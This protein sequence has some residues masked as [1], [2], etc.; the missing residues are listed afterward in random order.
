MARFSDP[1]VELITI[2]CGSQMGKTESLMNVLGHRFADGPRVPTLWIAPTQ[3]SVKSLA[4]DRVM[5]MIKGTPALWDILDK[6]RR[7]RMVEKFLA[8]VRLGFGWA[9]SA[10]ELASHPAGLVLVD[11]RD[12]MVSDV[13][14]EGDPLVLARARTKNYPLRKIGVSSTPTIEGASPIWSLFLEGTREKW[15]W[16]CPHCAEYFVPRLEYLVWPKKATPGEARRAAFVVCPSCG[17]ELRDVDK[18]D[19]NARGRFIP[20]VEDERGEEQ[21]I[22]FDGDPPYNS[23]ASYWISGLASP[24]V[25]FG[26][27]AEMLVAAYRSRE[28]ERI[29]G[30]VNT[31]GGEVWKI[32]GDAPEWQTVLRTRGHY[33]R[34]NVPTGVRMITCGVDVQKEG[35]YYVVRGWGVN[36]ESWLL[37]H[38]YLYG[39]TEYD[40]VWLSLGNLITAPVRDRPIDRVFVD[41]GYR[42]GQLYRR[43]ENVIYMFCRRHRGLA[44]PSK[45]HDTQDR[46]LKTADLDLS[47]GGRTIRGAL[48]LWHV[49]T[50][51]LKT[52]IYSQIDL[53][54]DAPVHWH[55]HAQ[56]DDD[57]AKQVVSEEVVTKS[58]GAR[59]W[60]TRGDNHYLDCEGLAFAAALSLNV[61]MLRDDDIPPPPPPD[62]APSKPARRRGFGRREL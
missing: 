55:T 2:V 22:P 8:N 28:P 39:R 58:S 9:G 1:D 16:P 62:E 15:A 5:K 46:P 42:P 13:E 53:P 61:Y 59:T 33:G 3:K 47:I 36:A 23:H 12:R 19:M 60:L 18:V 38:G 56:I 14:G 7:N 31:Y 52:W 44:Y 21:A 6:G 10:T 20:H 48:K 45:G 35:L 27:L 24:W 54:P 17:A 50:D 30:V 26:E 29:Q 51:Y 25:T 49:N 11:E 57:Y 32:S 4:D 41:S 34:G 40:N 43:P 37:D